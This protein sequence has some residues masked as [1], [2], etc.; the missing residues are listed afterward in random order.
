MSTRQ[1]PFANIPSHDTS[2]AKYDSLHLEFLSY[3]PQDRTGTSCASMVP[4][5]DTSSK[6]I[7][8]CTVKS[9]ASDELPSVRLATVEN[10]PPAENPRWKR[11]FRGFESPPGAFAVLLLSMMCLAFFF[12]LGGVQARRENIRSDSGKQA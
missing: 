7:R 4:H 10:F 6:I 8:P 11:K 2:I 1:H 12:V 3:T 5:F 9:W